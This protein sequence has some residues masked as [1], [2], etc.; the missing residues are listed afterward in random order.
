MTRDTALSR[1][2][3]SLLN[4]EIAVVP[5]VMRHLVAPSTLPYPPA[6][7]PQRVSDET[8]RRRSLDPRLE[9]H[10]ARCGT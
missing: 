1:R 8:G 10:A 9:G 5:R 2:L 7:R 6:L 4:P 3:G